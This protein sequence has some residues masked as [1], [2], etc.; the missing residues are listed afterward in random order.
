MRPF[1]LLAF[2]C[3]I[4]SI[5]GFAPAHLKAQSASTSTPCAVSNGIARIVPHGM[6]DVREVTV[7][8]PDGGVVYLYSPQLG[9]HN[10]AS[11]GGGTIEVNPLSQLGSQYA[12]DGKLHSRKIFSDSGSYSLIVL[13]KASKTRP[14]VQYS[15]MG[16]SLDFTENEGFQRVKILDALAKSAHSS[17]L[18]CPKGEQPALM[19]AC[20]SSSGCQSGGNGYCCSE[21]GPGTPCY[22]NNCCVA[23]AP[24]ANL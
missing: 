5:I 14:Q 12:E 6:T 11:P 21:G 23:L 7:L 2:G 24:K 17:S 20:R 3:V 4:A 9:V 22:C 10:L 8:R 1:R 16:C 13:G 19:A 18:A 15:R